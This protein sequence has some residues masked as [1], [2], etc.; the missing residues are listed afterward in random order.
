MT[1]KDV[2]TWVHWIGFARSALMSCDKTHLH[3]RPMKL[4]AE[5]THAS[6]LQNLTDLGEKLAELIPEKQLVAEK[7]G[8]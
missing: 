5:E 1:T 2:L 3:G 8:E 4:I 6:L 7:E